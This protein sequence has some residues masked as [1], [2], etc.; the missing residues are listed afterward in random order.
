MHLQITANITTADM[1]TDNV[2]CIWK[3][4]S[5][6]YI[7]DIHLNILVMIMRNN[8]CIHTG[9]KNIHTIGSTK[10]RTE[11]FTKYYFLTPPPLHLQRGGQKYSEGGLRKSLRGNKEMQKGG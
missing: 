8:V 3:V 4:H 2:N 5:I 6:N 9:D 1:C 11:N 10:Q 7:V